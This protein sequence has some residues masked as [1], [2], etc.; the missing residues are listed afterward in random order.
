MAAFADAQS[1][2]RG[3]LQALNFIFV[4]T[5]SDPSLRDVTGDLPRLERRA[6][7]DVNVGTRTLSLVDF[8][9]GLILE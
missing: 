6:E 7:F 4:V 2:G 9:W 3:H 1:P 8:L 5:D